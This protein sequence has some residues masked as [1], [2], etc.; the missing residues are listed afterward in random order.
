MN[1]QTGGQGY[2]FTL[3][4]TSTLDRG[5]MSTPHNGRFTA[6]KENL[7]TLYRRTGGPRDLSGRVRKSSP[8]PGFDPI[9]VKQIACRYID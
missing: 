1:Y 9:T 2:S 3:S 5:G 6:W 4:L 8:T 7:Y